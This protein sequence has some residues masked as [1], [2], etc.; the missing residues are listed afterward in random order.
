[1]KKGLATRVWR[2]VWGLVHE[3]RSDQRT[4]VIGIAI[5]CTCIKMQTIVGSFYIFVISRFKRS[6][7]GRLLYTRVMQDEI[8]EWNWM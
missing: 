7:Y 5:C 4:E 8:E 3:T 6:G 1:M 2:G